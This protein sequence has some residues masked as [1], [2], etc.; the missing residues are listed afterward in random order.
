MDLTQVNFAK[1]ASFFVN[2]LEGI[3]GNGEAIPGCAKF[4]KV[5][6]AEMKNGLS[7]IEVFSRLI[8]Q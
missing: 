5:T 4:C 8:N 6:T 2:K 7:M 1:M 3:C